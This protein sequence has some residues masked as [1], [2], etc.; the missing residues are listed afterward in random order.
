MEVSAVQ[1]WYKDLNP[2]ELC[3][4]KKMSKMSLRAGISPLNTVQSAMG[5]KVLQNELG[6]S[7]HES[8]LA[9]F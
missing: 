6:K 5:H 2:M 7:Q 8:G 9:V 1:R 3:M 4:G